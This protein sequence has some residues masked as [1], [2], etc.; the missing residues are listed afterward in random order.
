LELT[1]R[2]VATLIGR[3]S[4]AVR[5]RIAR[6]E[7]PAVRRGNTWRIRRADLP[8]TEA[9][10]RALQARADEVRQAVDEALP[11][12][13]ARRPGDRR[14]SLADDRAFREAAALFRSVREQD[15]PDVPATS[16]AAAVS[17]LRDA[18]LEL[19]NATYQFDPGLKLEALSAARRHLSRLSA[20]LL[21]E[22]GHPPP[23]PVPDWIAAIE[24]LVLPAIAGSA[25]WAERL[26]RRR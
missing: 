22:T 9:Q 20:L 4:R 5:A 16:R 14:R 17:A 10:R 1:V 23:D 15:A 26:E 2:E 12:R 7:L 24:T 25:R 6:G 13:L 11:S 19:A 8:L 3:S 21:M 18:L